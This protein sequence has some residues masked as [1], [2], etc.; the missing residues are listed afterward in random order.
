[1]PRRTRL[2]LMQIMREL[3]AGPRDLA[4][5]RHLNRLSAITQP[6]LISWGLRDPL[7]TEGAG[8]RLA[9]ALPHGIYEVYGDL[10]HMPH[11]EAPE[12]IGRR[13]AEFFNQ[14]FSDY[15]ARKTF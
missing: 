11:E 6:V 13:W 2:R 10:A 8:E 3:P 15:P 4:G 5:H 1:M 12:R 7:L 9:A 14:D